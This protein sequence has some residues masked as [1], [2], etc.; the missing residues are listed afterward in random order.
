MVQFVIIRHGYSQF[1]KAGRF[2]GQMD[3]PLDDLGVQQA[4][5]TAEYV[6]SHFT[7]D[8]IY[9]SSL[10]RAIETA[11]PV[12]DALKLPIHLEDG[13]MEIY[14]G[15]WQGLLIEDIKKQYS[16]EFELWATDVGLARCGDGESTAEL[17]E[18]SKETFHKIAKENEGKTVLIST[19]G[20]VVGAIQCEWLQV[21]LTEMKKLPHVANASVT[22]ADYDTQT[23]TAKFLQIGYCEHLKE[24][25]TKPPLI[26]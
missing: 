4:K 12:A 13:L 1:N 11:K 15:C 5:L 10:S 24:C 6:V 14:A 8:E 23:R 16:K 21:P 26:L 20:G 18:R 22:V 2:T 7:I 17:I 19:H 25:A 9:S 3:I